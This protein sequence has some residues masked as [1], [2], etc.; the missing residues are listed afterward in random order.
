MDY[1]REGAL[2]DLNEKFSSFIAKLSPDSPKKNQVLDKNTQL[3]ETLIDRSP[4]PKQG[5]QAD[6]NFK[7]K[8]LT[9]QDAGACE[10]QPAAQDN[11]S[12]GQGIL[13]PR[14]RQL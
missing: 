14:G 13:R 7:G 11:A 4:E 9:Y 8:K 10:N 3:T 5:M 12:E 1:T 2:S 6:E